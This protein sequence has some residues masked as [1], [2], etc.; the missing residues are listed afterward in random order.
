MITK[1][2]FLRIGRSVIGRTTQ[3]SRGRDFK[4]TFGVSIAVCVDLWYSCGFDHDKKIK[5]KHM[6]WGLLKMKVYSNQSVLA[7]LAAI[8]AFLR[9]L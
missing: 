9:L 4:A 3:E 1:Y 2:N 7:A 8:K 5:P 6:M